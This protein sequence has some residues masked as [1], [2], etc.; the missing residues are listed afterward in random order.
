M[1]PLF[2]IISAAFLMLLFSDVPAVATDEWNGICPGGVRCRWH[3]NPYDGIA[4]DGLAP[5][6][7]SQVWMCQKSGF[8]YP[9]RLFDL[10]S[11]GF[12]HTCVDTSL[13][14][15]DIAFDGSILYQIRDGLVRAIDPWKCEVISTGKAPSSELD[16]TGLA[17][18]GEYLW[19]ADS[20]TFWQFT[21]PPECKVIKSCP[22]PFGLDAG[23]VAFCGRYLTWL[24]IV[25][26]YAGWH[27]AKMDPNSCEGAIDESCI[28]PITQIV[29]DLGSSVGGITSDGLSN[30]YIS[31]RHC[32]FFGFNCETY[33]LDVEVDCSDP[34]SVE[35]Q[36]WG[37]VKSFYRTENAEEKTQGSSIAP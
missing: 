10:T 22:N 17:W 34:T 30:V 8:G 9:I 13:R 20:Q 3:W 25:P 11:C 32:D 27:L 16:M 18:D 5:A 28:V 36:S 33:I 21:P 12:A 24:V 35:Q 26:P 19:Q 31:L 14:G 29:G 1:R 23:G 37:K 7:N 15:E 4:A 6:G 2:R